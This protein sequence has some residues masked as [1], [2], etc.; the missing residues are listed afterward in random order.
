MRT[1]DKC[2]C[3]SAGLAMGEHARQLFFFFVA[4]FKEEASLF[5]KVGQ[6]YFFGSLSGSC[7]GT[8]SLYLPRATLFK[9]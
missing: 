1:G 5:T 7:N 2:S 8:R 9:T 4:L 6:P 3:V